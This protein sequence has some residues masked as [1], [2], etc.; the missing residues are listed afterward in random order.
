MVGFTRR[1]YRQISA[2]RQISIVVDM[3]FH[4]PGQKPSVKVELADRCSSEERAPLDIGVDQHTSIG[5]SGIRYGEGF[6]LG[7]RSRPP[8]LPANLR[9]DGRCSARVGGQR[10]QFGPAPG[11]DRDAADLDAQP[12]VGGPPTLLGARPRVE[13]VGVDHDDPILADTASQFA[14]SAVIPGYEA[15]AQIAK[16]CKD[17]EIILVL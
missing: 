3:R 16:T 8:R 13:H 9:G 11:A 15:S 4:H 12:V 2:H 6:S 10:H 7:L 17:S 1:R 14:G 5:R